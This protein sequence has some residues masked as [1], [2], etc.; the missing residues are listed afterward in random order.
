M[1]KMYRIGSNTF[2]DHM[3]NL[4]NWQIHDEVQEGFD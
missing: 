3:V 4:I 1:F 2:I